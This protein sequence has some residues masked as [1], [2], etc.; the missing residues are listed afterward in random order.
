MLFRN[1]R[2][3]RVQISPLGSS[4]VVLIWLSGLGCF[5]PTPAG[6]AD[7]VVPLGAGSYSL[8]LPAGARL[9]PRRI[10]AAS[11]LGVKMPTND[12]WSS[13]A[14]VP[15]S[16][17]QFPH[18]LGVQAEPTGLR[19]FHAGAGLTAN[20][21]GIFG[22][23]P[24][25]GGGDL[26]L[27]HSAQT[28]FETAEVD[29][30]SDWFV[31]ARFAREGHV[32]R[33]SYGHGSPFVFA[34]FEGGTPRLT[35]RETPSILEGDEQGLVLGL[36]VGNRH[37]GLF[38]PSGGKWSGIGTGTITCLTDKPYFSLA[39]LPD[40]SKATLDLFQQHSYAH[41]VDTQVSWNYDP[42]SSL[43]RTSFRF[44]TEAMEGSERNTMFALYP[45]QWR[46]TDRTLVGLEYPSVRGRLKLAAGNGFDT[47][48]AY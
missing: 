45:H 40:A 25:P 26:T 35:F 17:R 43:V 13:L 1:L 18:P 38:A 47:K 23:S 39:V 22:F 31:T 36:S 15:F 10:Y 6:A 11:G 21:D 37:Y 7:R 3:E 34:R 2:R 8:T 12:W 32:L 42:R 48:M 28:E 24:G 16:D 5:A 27:G 30:F 4:F 14:W 29:G 33:V 19:V 41:V 20:K 9:P 44:T 46:H